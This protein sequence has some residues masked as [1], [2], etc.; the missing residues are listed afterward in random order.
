MFRREEHYI[1]VMDNIN[2]HH[3]QGIKRPNFF[4][5]LS[6][7]YC[8]FM[9]PYD[10]FL[11]YMLFRQAISTF[12]RVESKKIIIPF[13]LIFKL[14]DLGFKT[15]YNQKTKLSYLGYVGFLKFPG[16]KIETLIATIH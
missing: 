9:N 13:L 16:G 8:L 3:S 7:Q 2:I 4:L 6:T 10:E 1:L 5:L 12:Y 11:T 15:G 14:D